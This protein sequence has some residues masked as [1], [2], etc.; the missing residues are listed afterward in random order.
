[1]STT[2]IKYFEGEEDED[3]RGWCCAHCKKE[4]FPSQAHVGI[5]NP[6][7]QG[8]TLVLHTGNSKPM[9]CL[10]KWYAERRSRVQ[11]VPSAGLQS[12]RT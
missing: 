8:E 2:H 5:A 11:S 4:V 12:L 3:V 9:D 10:T 7:S 6:D 1:M